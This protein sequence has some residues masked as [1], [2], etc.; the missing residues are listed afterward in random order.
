MDNQ[1]GWAPRPGPMVLNAGATPQQRPASAGTRLRQKP[2]GTAPPHQDIFAS[3]GLD[4][5]RN[6]VNYGPS[7]PTGNATGMNT[8]SAAPPTASTTLFQ[9]TPR[10]ATTMSSR[11]TNT[12]TTTTT[13]NRFMTPAN[14]VMANTSTATSTMGF[15]YNRPPSTTTA[16]PVAP[17]VAPSQTPSAAPP[18]ALP[19]A[20]PMAP[21][22]APPM[23]PPMADPVAPSLAPPI[24]PPVAPPMAAPVAPPIAPPSA[25]QPAS[26]STLSRPKP[27][28]FFA[29][30]DDTFD[31]DDGWGCDSPSTVFSNPMDDADESAV[32][33]EDDEFAWVDEEPIKSSKPVEEPGSSMS[34]VV[35]PP[36]AAPSSSVFGETS[37]APPSPATSAFGVSSA[38]ST[39]S[40]APLPTSSFASPPSAALSA[41]GHSFHSSSYQTQEHRPSQKEQDEWSDNWSD[42]PAAPS[43]ATPITSAV[44]ESSSALAEQHSSVASFVTETATA[45]SNDFWGAQDDDALFD[46]PDEQWGE[47]VAVEDSL[48][49]LSLEEQPADPHVGAPSLALNTSFSQEF[50]PEV[51]SSASSEHNTS[52]GSS[53]LSTSAVF[54]SASVSSFTSNAE[55]VEQVQEATTDAPMVTKDRPVEHSQSSFKGKQTPAEAVFASISRGSLFEQ[56][57]V[58]KE[59][60]SSHLHDSYR[61]ESHSNIQNSAHDHS[62]KEI[63]LKWDDQSGTEDAAWGNVQ[64][65]DN[66]ASTSV[67]QP[68]KQ[69]TK[70]SKEY[71][72]N[73][74]DSQHLF[75]G[76]STEGSYFNSPDGGNGADDT[77]SFEHSASFANTRHAGGSVVSFGGVSS[78]GATFGG[79]EHASDDLYS[80]GNA[81]ETRSLFGSSN[82]S[83]AFGT[84]F[85]SVSEGQFSVAGTVFE[86]SDASDDAPFSDGNGS[87]ARSMFGSSTA[88][89]AFAQA[90][91]VGNDT[92][93]DEPSA[94]G[95]SSSTRSELDSDV[96]AASSIFGVSDSVDASQFGAPR[97]SDQQEDI[98]AAASLFG[99]TSG[100]DVP[101]PFSSFGAP[102]SSGPSG[103]PEHNLPTAN[104]ADLFGSAPSGGDFNGSFE[105]SAQQYG[106]SSYNSYQQVCASG[107]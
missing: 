70:H 43:A 106:E 36:V 66:F 11:L 95:S 13:S 29:M 46:Q 90:G 57:S 88:S 60:E 52:F 24:V 27:T 6:R 71:S 62:G 2:S 42:K 37:A 39:S 56:P 64:E 51:A 99:T 87:E 47:S 79:S 83:T 69:H 73:E 107:Q 45:S 77:F 80:D 53:S 8:A 3:L 97:S 48:E 32:I 72:P 34:N 31:G 74:P 92:A 1:G 25:P 81:S 94:F 40:F 93:L 102:P 26:V 101:N 38:P 20:S 61:S 103:F 4:A 59:F 10:Q 98:P 18:M 78:A 16:P 65:T 63:E 84:D 41:F 19:V 105:Q 44:H 96:P 75:G 82:A 54:T 89:T 5:S 12:T 23:A 28:Q 9:Y 14:R 67:D 33:A 50:Q 104:A 15:G 100:S 91:S 7:Q 21:S 76:E 85:P 30:E 49:K 35:Q 86:G 55:T 17:L 58:E 68:V 22:M